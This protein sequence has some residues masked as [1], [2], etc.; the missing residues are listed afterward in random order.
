MEKRFERYNEI[1]F[2][3]YCK[4]SIERAIRKARMEKAE[5][6]AHETSLNALTEEFLYRVS[7]DCVPID[8]QIC[9]TVTFTVQ[10]AIIV[11]H[12]LRLGQALTYLHPRTRTILLMSYFLELSDAK[13]A[14]KLNLSKSAVQRW[15]TVGERHLRSLLEGRR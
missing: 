1:T 14:D 7:G 5:R 4:R 10:D 15:R 13:I 8:E 2:E 11:V 9:E 3:A 12:D 6:A